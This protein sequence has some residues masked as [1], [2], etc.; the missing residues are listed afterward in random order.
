[1]KRFS[2]SIFIALGILSATSLFIFASNH[3]KD[4]LCWI[5]SC[6]LTLSSFGVGFV[7]T[8]HKEKQVQQ[9]NFIQDSLAQILSALSEKNTRDGEL[10]E[11]LLEQSSNVY[12]K[13]EDLFQKQSGE[14]INTLEHMKRTFQAMQDAY[15]SILQ[16]SR[17]I[18]DASQKAYQEKMSAQISESN[19]FLEH[20]SSS[21]SNQL[22]QIFNSWK[23]ASKDETES[24]KSSSEQYKKL[25]AD[26]ITSYTEMIKSHTAEYNV[27][28]DSLTQKSIE[29]MNAET[30]K[31]KKLREDFEIALEKINNQNSFDAEAFRILLEDCRK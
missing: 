21:V 10:L 13:L 18:M 22:E 30:E 17:K 23:A 15:L 27:L 28:I 5:F 26:F 19:L 6:I 3:Q 4:S 25:M 8:L 20:F 9:H 14:H 29:T 24:L 1:M 12:R 11:N 16:D 2:N 7:N 31:F